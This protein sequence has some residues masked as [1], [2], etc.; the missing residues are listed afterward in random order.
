MVQA[1]M[2]NQGAK[3]NEKKSFVSIKFAAAIGGLTGG[4]FLMLTGLALS[5]FHISTE[6]VFTDWT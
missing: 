3:L 6:R 1:V 5:A 4:L 2:A